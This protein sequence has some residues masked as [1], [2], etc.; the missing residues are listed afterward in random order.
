MECR[1]NRG[2]GI[3]DETLSSDKEG[4]KYWWNKKGHQGLIIKGQI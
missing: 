1:E 3:N 2:E 4:D